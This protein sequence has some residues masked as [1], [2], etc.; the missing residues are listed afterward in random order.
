MYAEFA[1]SYIAQPKMV[2][3]SLRWLVAV[4]W[5]P[6]LSAAESPGG[7]ADGFVPS[8]EGF[9]LVIGCPREAREALSARR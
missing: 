2:R 3:R 7:P 9:S 1:Q 5:A 4:M 8:S 6:T